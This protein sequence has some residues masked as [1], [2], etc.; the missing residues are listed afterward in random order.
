MAEEMF[1]VVDEHDRVVGVAPRSVA[2]AQKLRH[3]AVHVFLFNLRH[4]LFVQKRA[5]TKDSFPRCYDSSASGHVNSGEEYDACAVRELEEELGVV[6]PA[7]QFRKH[8][9]IEACEDTGWEFVWA[10]S[11]ISDEPPRINLVELESGEFWTRDDIRRLLDEHPEQFA[12][13]FPMVFR[14]FDRGGLWPGRVQRPPA[15]G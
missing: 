15:P 14:E 9:K 13:S 7:S 2:H 12:R 6:L 8:F 4:D 3:R 11:V 10:Y 5:A 1:D